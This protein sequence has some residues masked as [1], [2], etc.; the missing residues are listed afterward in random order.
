MSEANPNNDFEDDLEFLLLKNISSVPAST[1]PAGSPVQPQPKSQFKKRINNSNQN[2]ALRDKSLAKSFASLNLGADRSSARPQFKPSSSNDLRLNKKT[3]DQICDDI[4]ISWDE[5]SNKPDSDD[6][7][8]SQNS[9]YLDDFEA[10]YYNGL[11]SENFSKLDTDTNAK[12]NVID[13]NSQTKKQTKTDL[14][15]SS[16]SLDLNLADN[17]TKINLELDLDNQ[18]LLS[19]EVGP[20]E[21]NSEKQKSNKKSGNRKKKSKNNIK[22]STNEQTRNEKPKEKSRKPKAT[23]I[24]PNNSNST[25]FCYLSKKEIKKFKTLKQKNQLNDTE[26]DQLRQL[27]EK[28][29]LYFLNKKFQQEIPFSESSNNANSN[30]ENKLKSSSSSSSSS[31]QR[32]SKIHQAKKPAKNLAFKVIYNPVSTMKL[33]DPFLE[34]IVLNANDLAKEILQFLLVHKDNVFSDFY[35][36]KLFFTISILVALKGPKSY[37][38][39]CSDYDLEIKNESSKNKELSNPRYFERYSEF[40]NPRG[41]FNFKLVGYIGHILIWG[42]DR[43]RYGLKMQKKDFNNTFIFKYQIK[44]SKSMILSGIGGM[45]LWDKNQKKDSMPLSKWQILN[46]LKKSYEFDED[47]FVLILR[48]MGIVDIPKMI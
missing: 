23:P 28:R 5:T 42:F 24:T 36:A 35:R 15:L 22:I 34:K 13:T 10:G 27:K 30:T 38:D 17:P 37:K 8:D 31:N 12:Q 29:K 21:I 48:F 3:I 9:G 1:V 33:S 7:D 32:P 45:N 18:A 43:Q 19:K 4:D 20:V 26:M 46:G 41:D 40:L 47:L 11:E 25:E 44:C 2:A 16:S 14:T 6:S 39:L